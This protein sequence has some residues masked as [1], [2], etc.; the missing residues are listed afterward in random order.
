MTGGTHGGG[1]FQITHP[2]HRTVRR[3]RSDERERIQLFSLGIWCFS[4]RGLERISKG[5]F[6][7]LLKTLLFLVASTW[8]MEDRGVNFCAR[9]GFSFSLL[10]APTTSS[11]SSLP[12]ATNSVHYLLSFA[13]GSKKQ[14]QTKHSTQTF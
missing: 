2:I 4:S 9:H 1:G 6:H 10:S 12:A 11:P 13:E 5:R 3:E 8:P 14:G 7:R